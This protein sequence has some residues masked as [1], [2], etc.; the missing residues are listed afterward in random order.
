MK[1]WHLL[2]AAAL[3]LTGAVAMGQTRAACAALACA[4]GATICRRL[5]K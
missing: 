5:D 4:I 1:K 3:A 2:T